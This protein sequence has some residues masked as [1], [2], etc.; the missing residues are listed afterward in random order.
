MDKVLYETYEADGVYDNMDVNSTPKVQVISFSK[1][2]KNTGEE[3]SLGCDAWGK[4]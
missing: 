3:R 4:I 1:T 2:M